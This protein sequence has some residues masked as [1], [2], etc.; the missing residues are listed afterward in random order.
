MKPVQSSKFKVQ[1]HFDFG[2]VNS[3]SADGFLILNFS[4]LG[5]LAGRDG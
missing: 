3:A 4:L 5:G 2:I 1:N